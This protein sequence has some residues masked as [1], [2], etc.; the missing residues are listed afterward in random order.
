MRTTLIAIAALSFVS[1]VAAAPPIQVPPE[2]AA[3]VPADLRSYYIAFKVTPATP[4]A[5]STEIFERH[6]AYIREQI[7]KKVYQ[8]VG[9]V[10]DGG[11]IRGLTI[12]TASSLEEARRIVEADPAV[13][14]KVLDVEVHPAVFPNLDSLKVLYPPKG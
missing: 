5:M 6:Q 3:H 1:P 2:V 7:E 11:R 9:P 14:D 12:M 10:T 8:L 4:K 13:Q